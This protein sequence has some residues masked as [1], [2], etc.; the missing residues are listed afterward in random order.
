MENSEKPNNKE[1]EAKSEKQL[2]T[3]Q[4]E[5]VI[6]FLDRTN[7][8]EY[9][10]KLLSGIDSEKPDFEEFK[11]FIVRINGILRDIPIAERITDGKDV[12]LSGL[13]E[14]VEVLRHEDKEEVLKYA[15]EK[16]STVEK[17]DLKYLLPAI[18]NAT[19]LFVD[20][21]GRTSRT[22]HLLLRDFSSKEEFEAEMRKALT[23]DGRYD[24]NDINPGL[25][26]LDLM[27]EVL[28]KHGWQFD[29]QHP[30]GRLNVLGDTVW[31]LATIELEDLDKTH[32]SYN[33]AKKLS[34]YCFG[35]A[36]YVLTAIN[37]TLGDEGVENVVSEWGHEKV[38]RISLKKMLETLSPE[39]W[40]KMLD[41]YD[42]LLKE[43]T[44]ALVDMFSEP[45]EF[46]VSNGGGETLRDYFIKK[47]EA[48]RKENEGWD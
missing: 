6:E 10:K 30:N 38:K 48:V 8:F 19:H 33:N 3:E 27:H 1:L 35:N 20:G 7:A 11:D 24:S 44:E 41:D 40:T 32:P 37:E 45:D 21:N 31:G 13:W 18:I 4:T 15:F 17:E 25:V 14:N 28:K 42:R 36:G 43:Q 16:A 46:K 34:K 2:R 29:V 23:E 12:H 9:F 47:I 22:M 26:R 5:K 39:Q